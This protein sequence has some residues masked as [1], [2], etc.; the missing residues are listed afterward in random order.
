MVQQLLEI[1]FFS[2][3]NGLVALDKFFIAEKARFSDPFLRKAV[4]CLVDIA[5]VKLIRQVLYNYIITGNY[6][7]ALFLR[8]IVIAETILAIHQR[9]DIDHIFSFLVPSYFGLEFDSTVVDMYRNFVQSHG[10]RLSQN[11]D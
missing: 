6:T 8:N 4:S 5:D 9:V 2:R 1:A 10:Y 11:K 7:G 3:E